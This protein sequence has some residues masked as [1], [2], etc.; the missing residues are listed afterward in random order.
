MIF[1][2]KLFY[3]TALLE[4][5]TAKIKTWEKEKGLPFMYNKASLVT[6]SSSFQMKRLICVD[7]ILLM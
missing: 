1:N 7:F 5:L 3:S 2:F 6:Q 4:N